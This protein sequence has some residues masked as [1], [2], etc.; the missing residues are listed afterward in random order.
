MIQFLLDYCEELLVSP[1]YETAPVGMH[2]E[3]LFLNFC[4]YVEWDVQPEVFKQQLT[5]WEERLGRDRANPLK[6]VLDRPADFDILKCWE[7][8][9]SLIYNEKP[10]VYAMVAC[11]DLCRHLEL[12]T[13]YLTK[14]SFKHKILP[15]GEDQIGLSVKHLVKQQ[16]VS[17]L[18]NMI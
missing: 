12:P 8:Q 16:N 10:V 14:Q 17:S 13:P 1:I 4:V 7:L 15:W 18:E 5:F 9:Y 11:N 3:H 2:S 6:K